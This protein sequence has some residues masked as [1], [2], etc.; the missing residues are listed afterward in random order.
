MRS[1]VVN[2]IAS[3]SIKQSS[4]QSIKLTSNRIDDALIEAPIRSSPW[5]ID[6]LLIRVEIER[7]QD[8][9]IG[10]EGLDG[11]PPERRHVQEIA[12]FEHGRVASSISDTREAMSLSCIATT[13]LWNIDTTRSGSSDIGSVGIEVDPLIGSVEIHSLAT[14]SLRYCCMAH[15]CMIDQYSC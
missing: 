3:L 2:Q 6:S 5:S 10:I 15:V 7:S 1:I 9:D 12:C 14:G 8:R 11:V 4:K 13:P